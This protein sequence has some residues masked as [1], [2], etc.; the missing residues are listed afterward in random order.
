MKQL[1]NR[2]DVSLIA[3]V[4]GAALAVVTWFSHPFL[5]YIEAGVWL[6]LIA[7]KVLFQIIKKERLLAQVRSMTAALNLETGR[8]FA[9]LSVPCVVVDNTGAVRWLNPAFQTAFA[10]DE[11]TRA[12]DLKLL[13]RADQL[14]PLFAGR[15]VRVHAGE[16]YFAVYS[17]RLPKPKGG[18][19]Y[20][21][22]FFDE[23]ELRKTEQAFNASRPSV[24]LTV[25]D[26]ADDLFQEFKESECA[27]IFS[28][29]EQ[30]IDDWAAS[31]G[32]LCRKLSSARMLIIAEE[33]GLRG[34]AEDKFSI[35]DKV[36]TFTYE[37]R[38]TDLTLSIGVGREDSIIESN[39]SAKQGLDMAQSR[40][41]D[42]VAIRHEGQYQFFGGVSSGFEHRSKAKTRLMAQTIGDLIRDSANVL[43]MGHRYS[44]YDAIGSAIGVYAMCAHLKKTA[45]I[46]VD[47]ATTLSAP[48]CKHFAARAGRG[49][50]VSPEYA[51]TLAKRDTLVIVVDT[52]KK[53]FTECP[54]LLDL[55]E[56]VIVIDHHRK[57]VGFIENAAVFYHVPTASSASEMVTELCQ[58]MDK[59]PILGAIEAQALFSGI[60]L[61][62]R[63]FIIRTGVRTFESAAYLRARG[64][65][66]VEAKKLFAV[67]MD[68]FHRRNQII[69]Q[70]ERYRDSFAI[71]VTEQQTD[72]LR[73]I[74]SQAADEMLNIERI[75]ASFVIFSAGGGINISARSYGEV[76]VQVLME[77]LGGGGHQTMAACQLG[78]IPA[79]Q[80]LARLKQAIDEMAAVS[81]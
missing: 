31:H 66:T 33:R 35:L 34:M 55:C 74:A 6:A 79:A 12:V 18:A 24:I 51:L 64:A 9:D 77:S 59:R 36:R 17:A 13:L 20:L 25:L 52:H 22:Y 80:A 56:K 23:T 27:A 40:G 76:N 16:K 5:A 10:L 57:S 44:D 75:K 81:S 71:S 73:L 37:G 8:A 53:E 62:T 41:G 1:W 68:I 45:N 4:A 32:A 43:I 19:N 2:F 48:L 14:E 11:K 70:A 30:M 50:I 29:I 21:L 58:Y 69:D 3:W 7:A 54:G 28:V 78:D 67:D 46:V 49:I 47:A 42:Q 61:D 72:N 15:G 39:H 63:N 26:N 38:Q 65:N 60:A